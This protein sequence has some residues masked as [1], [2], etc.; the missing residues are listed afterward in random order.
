MLFVRCA[1]W[2]GG[3]F[4]GLSLLSSLIGFPVGEGNY[5]FSIRQAQMRKFSKWGDSSGDGN[6]SQYIVFNHVIYFILV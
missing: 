3:G 6:F 1:G 5:F 4:G 2:R